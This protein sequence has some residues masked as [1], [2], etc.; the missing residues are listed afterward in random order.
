MQLLKELRIWKLRIPFRVSFRHASATRTS[1]ESIWVE[2]VDSDGRVGYGESCPRSYVTGENL[3]SCM[4]FFA[5]H[6][7]ELCRQVRCLEDLREWT[8]NHRS[9]I[10]QSPAAWCAIELA[11]LDLLA[12]RMSSSVE[13]LLGLP[14]LDGTFC[15]TAVIG[16]QSE[17]AF[18]KQ[19][20]RYREVGFEQF[21]VKLSGKPAQ[22]AAKFGILSSDGILAKDVRVDANN[23]W[24][25]PRDATSYLSPL[26][27]SFFAIE[28]PLV[29]GDFQGMRELAETLGK[30]VILDESFCR[31]DQFAQIKSDYH[32]WL[33]N[34]RVS[35][36]GGLL[37]SLEVAQFACENNIGLVIGAQVGETS[38]LTRAALTV[39]QV[40]R[41]VLKGQEGAFGKLLLEADVIES[42]LTFGAR[43]R[44]SIL[45]NPAIQSPAEVVRPKA[46]LEQF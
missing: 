14:K 32:R 3:D 36:M 17:S 31:A 16:D 29:A 9:E 10:D 4:S 37:R 44:L 34:L 1:T 18:A 25:S 40:A 42:P 2:A 43:G 39:A 20:K 35:K 5:K 38:L 45:S 6:R 30:L 28:E 13:E 27:E 22:D 7:G 19:L 11:V 23:L 46:F 24:K 21:K 15:Y 8:A 33:I 12:R 41:P 26:A